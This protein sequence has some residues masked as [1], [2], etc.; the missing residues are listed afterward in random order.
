MRNPST[1]NYL[2]VKAT[3]TSVARNSKQRKYGET[4]INQPL[5]KKYE[6]LQCKGVIAKM[7]KL[8]IQQDLLL[9]QAYENIYKEK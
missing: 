2:T 5:C 8:H 9:S 1:K 7:F 4:S 3:M 6:A